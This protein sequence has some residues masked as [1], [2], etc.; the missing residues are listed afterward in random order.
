MAISHIASARMVFARDMGWLRDNTSK[1]IS[2]SRDNRNDLA[3]IIL[4]GAHVVSYRGSVVTTVRKTPRVAWQDFGESL[5][6]NLL[7]PRIRAKCSRGTDV[8]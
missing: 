4:W 6:A 1:I 7:S 5:S 8:Y 3:N 2:R